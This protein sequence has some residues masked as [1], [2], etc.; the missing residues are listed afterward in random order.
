MQ[1]LYLRRDPNGYL[2][3]YRHP[4]A[5][6]PIVTWPWSSFTQPKQGATSHCVNGLT[7]KLVW[8]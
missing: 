1:T 6:K 2:L 5:S 4:H 8:L 3:G 7:Y